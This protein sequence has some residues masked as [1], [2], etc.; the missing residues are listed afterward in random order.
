LKTSH[1]YTILIMISV[2]CS[3][4]LTL[5]TYFYSYGNGLDYGAAWS[6]NRGLPLSWATEMHSGVLVFPQPAFYPF[7]F[8]ALNFALDVVLWAT[9]LLLVSSSYLYLK[10]S[11]SIPTV[12]ELGFPRTPVGILAVASI[13]LILDIPVAFLVRSYIGAAVIW[14]PYLANGYDYG[15]TI[16]IFSDLLFLEGIV[17]LAIGL[18]STVAGA[19]PIGGHARPDTETLQKLREKTRSGIWASVIGAIFFGAGLL[20]VFLPI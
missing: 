19:I 18:G 1:G 11:Q 10:S 12:R 13:V 14:A 5:A 17:A 9:V 20:V 16:G 6:V 8:Q 7:N 3:L 4:A 15:P 2:I